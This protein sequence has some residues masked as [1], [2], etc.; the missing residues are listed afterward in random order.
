MLAISFLFTQW[1]AIGMSG[2]AVSVEH[3]YF[4]QK[5]NVRYSTRR[6]SFGCG[7]MRKYQ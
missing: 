6:D 5:L 1:F 4:A 7:P 3:N 2:R